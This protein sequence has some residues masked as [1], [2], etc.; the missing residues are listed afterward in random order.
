MV[1]SDKPSV[2]HEDLILEILKGLQADNAEIRRRLDSIE[3]RLSAHDDFFRGIMTTLA[4]ILSDVAQL[5]GRVD[6]IERR[7][8]L[9][10][11]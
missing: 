5:N 4:G 6:R 9:V 3:V 2:A 7:L 1:L 10:E 8:G 11:G